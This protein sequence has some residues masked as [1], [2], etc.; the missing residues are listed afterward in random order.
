VTRQ[1]RHIGVCRIL[2]KINLDIYLF[3]CYIIIVEIETHKQKQ[4]RDKMKVSEKIKSILVEKAVNDELPSDL[5]ELDSDVFE[6]VDKMKE[7]IDDLIWQY[8][9]E[10]DDDWQERLEEIEI[11]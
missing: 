10:G 6:F 8:D 2:L 1:V 5:N 11:D 7:L 9:P 4:R 3:N